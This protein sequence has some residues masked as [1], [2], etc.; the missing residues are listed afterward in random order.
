MNSI[1]GKSTGIA[2]LMAAA[3]LAALFAMGVFSATGVG[4]TTD[5]H[6]ETHAA[7][8]DNLEVYSG[9]ASSS[10]A[11]DILPD[12]TGIDGTAAAPAAAGYTVTIPDVTV[13]AITLDLS[14][15]PG[16]EIT[17]VSGATGMVAYTA[18]GGDEVTEGFL[19]SD[20]ESVEFPVVVPLTE[21]A[22]SR[23]VV[24]VS[25]AVAETGDDGLIHTESEYVINVVHTVSPSSSKTAGAAVRLALQALITASEGDE[26]TIDL[27]DFGLPTT[28]DP[29]DVTITNGTITGNPSDVVVSGSKV[30][31][32]FTDLSP[33]DDATAGQTITGGTSTITFR[34]RAGI[35]NPTTAGSY[36]I[37]IADEDIDEI[38]NGVNET[39]ADPYVDALNVAVVVRSVSVAPKKGARGS[40][41]TITGKGFSTGDATVFIDSAR[42]DDPATDDSEAV[43]VNGKYDS[44]ID[45]FLGTAPISDGSFTLTIKVGSKFN[46]DGSENVI[47]AIDSSGNRALMAN[48]AGFKVTGSVVVTPE[49]ISFSEKLKIALKDW[50]YGAVR[51]VQ[52][53]GTSSAAF[54]SETVEGVLT[55][56]VTVPSGIRTGTHQVKVTGVDGSLSGSAMVK[57]LDLEVQPEE[58]VPGQQ[59]TVKGSGFEGG[60]GGQGVT[61]KV[62]SITINARDVSGGEPETNSS[63][64]LNIT[65]TLPDAEDLATGSAT[66]TV[67]EVTS[68]RSGTASLTVPAES[69]TLDPSESGYGTT[70]IIEGSGFAANESLDIEYWNPDDLEFEPI[71]IARSDSEG[72]FNGSFEVPAFAAAGKPND[73]RV[74]DRD[75]ERKATTTHSL[76]KETVAA[77][78]AAVT[79]GGSL[80]INGAN[81]PL[82]T[83]VSEV[84]V[85]RTD[86]TPS[87]K[88]IT[89]GNGDVSI[90]VV[91]PQLSLGNQP[92]SITIGDNVITDSVRIVTA[93][94]APTSTDPA[95]VFADLI[96]AGRLARVW[97]L[98]SSTQDWSFYDPDPAF[99]SFNS[100]TELPGGDE[101]VQVIISPGGSIEFQGRTLYQ[102][103]NFVN[104]N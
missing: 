86:V 99:A 58:A 45:K 85:G 44:G 38:A 28:I 42:M 1:V 52:F 90:V 96:E 8:L 2:L 55:L 11:N 63:G 18:F 31:L 56:T 65:F 3:M 74:M 100:L 87:P 93:S 57:P 10:A 83:T 72:E 7:M 89:D 14:A 26:I 51:N 75:G 97:Y 43:A 101:V 66:I 49:E 94:Q 4:A 19:P 20:T 22:V 12:D 50:P 76:P 46:T 67:E 80:T 84:K 54:T 77:D 35:T 16:T 29:D 5:G 47:N 23:L 62:G 69:L 82:H 64:N 37:K 103:T 15:E 39:D 30:S 59:V 60:S 91:V 81:L 102:G 25:D 53:G 61:I 33:D 6:T 36:G 48:D 24:T 104:P 9:D 92:I 71:G 40:D 70:V 41:I 98:D 68:N 88:P 13:R 17:E 21:G 73:V 32:Y 78:P 27:T 34:Q 79:A 95:E